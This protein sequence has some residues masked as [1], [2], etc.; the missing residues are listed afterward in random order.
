MRLESEMTNMNRHEEALQKS[1]QELTE[2]KY[3]VQLVDKTLNV[4]KR[5]SVHTD[6]LLN[7]TINQSTNRT[8]STSEPLRLED[9]NIG[10]VQAGDI[11]MDTLRSAATAAAGGDFTDSSRLSFL[12]G[13]IPRSRVFQFERMMWR[14]LRG[15]LVM[16]VEEIKEVQ[17]RG[18]AFEKDLLTKKAK[19]IQ[20]IREAENKLLPVEKNSFVVFIQGSA[21][22]NKIRK[23]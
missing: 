19:K 1:F 13:V 18:N 11:Q 3:V 8:T 10:L 9:D 20:V 14:Q 7:I 21:L 23:V 6:L 22:Q 15:N 2:M 5:S 17:R 12:A 4:Q 16:R